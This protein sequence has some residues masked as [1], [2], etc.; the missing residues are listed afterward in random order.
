VADILNRMKMIAEGVAT[1]KSAHELALRHDVEM[2]IIHQMYNILF[3]DKDPVQ[4]TRDLMTREA[5]NEVWW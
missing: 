1:T 2:P 3:E 4:A 5:K